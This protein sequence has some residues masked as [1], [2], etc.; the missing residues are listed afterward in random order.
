MRG[1]SPANSVR[2]SPKRSK[3]H[4]APLAVS[5]VRPYSAS[6]LVA[7]GATWDRP[8]LGACRSFAVTSF[9]WSAQAR[10]DGRERM[11]VVHCLLRGARVAAT[12]VAAQQASPS[13]VAAMRIPLRRSA[14]R[15]CRRRC[16]CLAHQ[17]PVNEAKTASAAS[18]RVDRIPPGAHVKP[19]A[20][21][22][23]EYEC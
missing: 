1:R 12:D 15:Q 4:R 22:G 9:R 11:G 10:V 8:K 20:R 21:D 2:H 19:E 5:F 16:Y 6:M 23:R 13:P 7:A 14:I 17:P 18:A 3:M